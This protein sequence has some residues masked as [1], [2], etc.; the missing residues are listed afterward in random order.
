MKVVE[1][2]RHAQR[3]AEQNLTPAGRATCA[4]A[5]E[6]LDLPYDAY[7]S[8]PKKRARLTIEALGGTESKVDERLVARASEVL[9]PLRARH[10]EE[11]RRRGDVVAAWFAIE[12]ALPALHETGV[13]V[14]AAVRDIAANLPEGGRALA[15]SH[16]G[17][18]EPFAILVLGQPFERALGSE[19][20]FCE[21]VRAFVRGRTVARLDVVRL[22]PAAEG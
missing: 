17:T 1:I 2:R 19:F 5:W 16:G 6:S 9:D 15:V 14:V 20:G 18:I 21:G 8:S 12:E 4:R 10:E 22:P 7:Y 11:A 3:D 13:R